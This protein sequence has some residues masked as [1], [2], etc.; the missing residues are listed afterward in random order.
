MVGEPTPCPSESGRAASWPGRGE[1]RGRS[2]PRISL[3]SLGSTVA[4]RPCG[5]WP[6][7]SALQSSRMPSCDTDVESHR[8]RTVSSMID[9][10]QRRDVLSQAGPRGRGSHPA[11]ASP[12]A[13]GSRSGF[14]DS[15]SDLVS[16]TRAAL[17]DFLHAPDPS[18]VFFTSGATASLN[19]VI[20]G[21]PLTGRHVVTT[22]IEHNSVLRPLT[23][24]ERAGVHSCVDRGK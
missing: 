1:R 24:L 7:A 15:A 3:E 17:S 8:V 13:G 9:P 2:F 21:L 11:A 22:T 4:R 16:D 23:R 18:S 6:V 19:T 5:V 14:E 12:P 20:R 10:E